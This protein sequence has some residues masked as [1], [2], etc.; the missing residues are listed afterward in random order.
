MLYNRSWHLYGRTK[1]L[2]DTTSSWN[3]L[4]IY[5]KYFVSNIVYPTD[6]TLWG[7]R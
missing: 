7:I 6:S 3:K 5:I 2:T 4:S 1:R